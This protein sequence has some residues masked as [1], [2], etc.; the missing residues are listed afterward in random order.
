MVQKMKDKNHLLDN[1]DRDYAKLKEL[2][3]K[4]INHIDYYDINSNLDFDEDWVSLKHHI[5]KSIFTDEMTF[6]SAEYVDKVIK[7]SDGRLN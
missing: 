4:I 1:I 5:N 6:Y 3:N 7:I 2:K